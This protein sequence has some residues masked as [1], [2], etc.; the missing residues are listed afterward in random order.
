MRLQSDNDCSVFGSVCWCSGK[1][2]WTTATID[3]A[4]VSAASADNADVG[5]DGDTY[6]VRLVLC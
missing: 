5:D 4:A 2:G 3:L 6:R 1:T